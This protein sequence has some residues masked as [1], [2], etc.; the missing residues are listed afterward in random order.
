MLPRLL[1]YLFSDQ[2]ISPRNW[3]MSSKYLHFL[4]FQFLHAY[5]TSEKYPKHFL[6]IIRIVLLTT[7]LLFFPS[8]INLDQYHHQRVSDPTTWE[9]CHRLGSQ[10]YLPYLRTSRRDPCPYPSRQEITAA[11]SICN[12]QARG[13]PGPSF[14]DHGGIG[15]RPRKFTVEAYAPRWVYDE[16]GARKWRH[17][18]GF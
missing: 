6:H 12:C 3:T 1:I 4:P 5:P 10:L 16:R 7:S 14:E 2:F 13:S 8:M 9:N 17:L 18:P 11:G 15:A